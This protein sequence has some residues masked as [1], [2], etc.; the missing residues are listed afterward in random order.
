MLLLPCR[1]LLECTSCP[2]RAF[3]RGSPVSRPGSCRPMLPRFARPWYTT[4]HR[5]RA[6]K[7]VV[8]CRDLR[9]PSAYDAPLSRVLLHGDAARARAE[10]PH[11]RARRS[12]QRRPV[13]AS[14]R[15]AATVAASRAVG[16]RG[17]GRRRRRRR[18]RDDRSA[19]ACSSRRRTSASS[20]AAPA[21]IMPTRCDGSSS[22]RRPSGRPRRPP[23][24]VRRR[25][26][27][28]SQCRRM[29]A[30]PRARRAPRS[31]RGRRSGAR[32]SASATSSAARRCSP[33]RRNGSRSAGVRLGLS[34]PAVIETA[35]GRGE[36]DAGDAAAVAAL[37]GAEARAAAGHVE[38]APTSADAMR[39]YVVRGLG[40]SMP[41]ATLG[42][43]R[44]RSASPRGSTASD[45]AAQRE[46]RLPPLP[47]TSRRSTRMPS[48]SMRA[49]LALRASATRRALARRPFGAG[50]FGPLR[51]ARA[52]RGAAGARCRHRESGGR[53]AGAPRRLRAATRFRDARKRCA[54]RNFSRSTPRVLAACA[55]AGVRLRGL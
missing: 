8:R 22:A 3:G 32:P 13:D 46:R 16:H 35:H 1:F 45:G 14:V 39:R 40:E 9:D 23:R 34:G 2:L 20:A 5:I 26:P 19:R 12:R 41:F 50:T 52:R 38:A 49:G 7:A 51:G 21:P 31:A 36:L 54:C 44:R 15:C 43:K 37:F 24:G 18:A 27:A 25:A 55:V 4:D 17:A 11:R 28:R 47:Q 48:R 53:D 33:A 10:Q 6:R 29:G 42:A 30:R